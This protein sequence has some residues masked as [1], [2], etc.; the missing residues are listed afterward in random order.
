MALIG[1]PLRGSEARHRDD[2][3][4]GQPGLDREHRECRRRH[5]DGVAGSD[6]AR[7]DE[8]DQ[9]VGAGAGDDASP[10]AR[11]SA[12]DRLAKSPIGR[13]PR[14]RQPRRDPR[15]A[16]RLAPRA[17][18][19]RPG[20]SCRSARSGRPADRREPPAPPRTARAGRRRS[21]L[22]GA[23]ADAGRGSPCDRPSQ[24]EDGVR[25]ASFERNRPTHCAHRRADQEEA[26]SEAAT[27]RD[28]VGEEPASDVVRM[29]GPSSRTRSVTRS[30]SSTST[31][32]GAPEVE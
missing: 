11:G 5:E 25:T 20:C 8:P 2:A 14:T 9:L 10:G 18:T 23:G 26:Q 6:D 16:R 12:A 1:L 17:A 30:P 27:R 13:G 15:R 29:P 24:R 28:P 3:C 4:P 31:W 7:R 32:I 22:R 21:G 19:R